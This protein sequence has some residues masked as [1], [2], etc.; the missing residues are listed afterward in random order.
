MAIEELKQ[1]WNSVV[2]VAIV[3]VTT[4]PLLLQLW[5]NDRANFAG[6]CDLQFPNQEDTRPKLPFI[7]IFNYKR[8]THYKLREPSITIKRK[9]RKKQVR[10]LK[11]R[12]QVYT[13]NKICRIF[14]IQPFSFDCRSSS[15]FF[16]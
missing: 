8:S 10:R 1:I 11:R 5:N 16:G 13:N 9:T 12:T 7:L 2:A 15:L 14:G 6:Y 3:A 4:L